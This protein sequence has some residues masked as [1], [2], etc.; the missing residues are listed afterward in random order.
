MLI[1]F[2]IT[3][4]L[5]ITWD[6]VILIITA[7]VLGLIAHKT[8]Q[9][10]L[11]AYLLAGIILGPVFFDV[12]EKIALL[13]VMSELGLAFLLFLLG[14]QLKF[15]AIKSILKPILRI[16]FW[17]TVLQTSLAF[18]IYYFLGFAMVE[19]VVM[20]LC[21]VFGATPVIVK[22]LDEKDEIDTLPGKIDVGVLIVQDI[23][24]V[25]YLT[26]FSAPD[27]TRPMPIVAN[28]FKVMVIMGVLAVFS[29]MVSE[30]VVPTIVKEV[31]NNKH[32]LFINGAAWAFLFI[33]ASMYLDVPVEVGSFIAG[34]GLAQSPYSDELKEQVR[35]ITDFFMMV[36][37]A[38]IGLSLAPAYLTIYLFEAIV[39]S[40]LLM[41]GNF[42]IMFYLI[43]R[44]KFSLETSF[45]GSI[46]MVQVS[47]FSLVV[48]ALAVGRGLVGHEI[49][50]YLSLMAVM[51]MGIS[52]YIIKYNHEIYNKVEHLFRFLESEEKEDI[53]FK[54]LEDH[55]VVVGY[56][57]ITRR[58]VPILKKKFGDVVL[59]D[60]NPKYLDM[61]SN[62]EAEFVFGNL[63]HGEMRRSIGLKRADIIVSLALDEAVNRRILEDKKS[64]AITFLR[65]KDRDEAAKLYDLGA[66]FVIIKRQLAAEKMT[67]YIE[68]FLE[69]PEEFDRK[70]AG[71]KQIICWE[72]RQ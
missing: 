55:A 16:S 61:S 9:P 12:V 31:G 6:F 1:D 28:F 5:F 52:A 72:A 18:V 10:N 63:K 45:L 44:E 13:E 36:F 3:E 41:L 68:A 20:A 35:P 11:I 59:I 54:V 57:E 42:L 2:T 29:Y 14:L 23:I 56:D 30:K 38:V 53:E 8:H 62:F 66:D 51:T 24:L 58:L 69:A 67:E 39:A 65:A 33:A 70:V 7:T 34:L 50:G 49:L 64:D 26:L 48:G 37:F 40:A 21:T 25:V 22:L 17:Q 47:E 15:D 4:G 43:D 71:D 60:K 46:N 19:V 27:L 32:L